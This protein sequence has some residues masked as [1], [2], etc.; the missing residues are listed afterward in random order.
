VRVQHLVRDLFEERGG[1]HDEADQRRLECVW[2]VVNHPLGMPARAARYA[3]VACP[4]VRECP[5][6]VG[7]AV[8]STPGEIPG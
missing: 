8:G 4:S 7:D 1:H 3:E 5:V 2:I 6:T